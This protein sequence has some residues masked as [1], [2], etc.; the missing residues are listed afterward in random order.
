MEDKS[1]EDKLPIW[2]LGKVKTNARIT[3]EQIMRENPD[4]IKQGKQKMDDEF[5]KALRYEDCKQIAKT[6]SD[7]DTTLKNP[8]DNFRKKE[9]L[10]KWFYDND[11]EISKVIGKVKEQ[12]KDSIKGKPSKKKKMQKQIFPDTYSERM[13]P[14]PFLQNQTQQNSQVEQLP[15]PNQFHE[16]SQNVYDSI[17]FDLDSFN[18]YNIFL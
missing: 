13:F 16:L 8:T 10:Y 11:K 18:N 17:K 9:I 7:I 5:G 15:Q 2:R 3:A 1:A 12:L 14:S 4:D 6:I